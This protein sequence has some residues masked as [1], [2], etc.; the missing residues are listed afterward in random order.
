MS[1][2]AFAALF[3]E[4]SPDAP[5]RAG[6]VVSATVVA[7]GGLDVVCEIADGR[8]FMVPLDERLEP[9]LAVGATLELLLFATDELGT[10]AASASMARKRRAWER[11]VAAQAGAEMLAATVTRR[12]LRG[13][14]VDL[15]GVLA[16]LPDDAAPATGP[17]QRLAVR[18]VRYDRWRESV[19]VAP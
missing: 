8:R 7:A 2:D 9:A 3:A 12:L 15:G 4:P 10:L 14:E 19:L 18:V 11:V 16:F 1:T 17:G 13:W 6:D 5:P